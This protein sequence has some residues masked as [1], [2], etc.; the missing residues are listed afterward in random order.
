MG[1][2]CGNYNIE[3][4][5]LREQRSSYKSNVALARE[6]CHILCFFLPLGCPVLPC[7]RGQIIQRIC[8]HFHNSIG[9]VANCSIFLH[10]Q[11]LFIFC[12]IHIR[13][14]HPRA[15]KESTNVSLARSNRL[16]CSSPK[17]LFTNKSKLHQSINPCHCLIIGRRNSLFLLSNSLLNVKIQLITSVNQARNKLIKQKPCL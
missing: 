11:F 14:E 13:T 12:N 3:G 16:D 10:S 9:K 5:T 2:Q 8:K 17:F 4:W 6:R 7:E 1:T 15:S